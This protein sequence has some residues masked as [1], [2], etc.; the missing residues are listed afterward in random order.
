MQPVVEIELGRLSGVERSGVRIFR[1]IPYAAPPLGP[2]RLRPPEP[3]EPWGGVRDA[4]RVGAAAPQPRA[5]VLPG[6]FRA[7]LGGGV[8]SED[9]LTLNVFTPGTD[10]GRRPVLVWIHGGAFVLGTGATPIY[11]GRRLARGGDAVVV[12]LNYRLGALGFAHL[13][14]LEADGAA[15][16]VNLGVQDQV[17]AL[18]FVRDHIAAFGGD[19]GNVTVFGESAGAMSVGTLLGTPMA[20]PLFQRAILQSGAA[21]NV[22]GPERAARAADTL[23]RELG[24]GVREGLRA[25]RE[26]PVEVVLAAQQRVTQAL[27]IAHGT[28]PWQPAVD[29]RI[30]PRQPL[31]AIA[32]GEA[33]GI[34]V[35]AGT[36]RDEWKLFTLFDSRTR[37]LDAAGL[38]RR[39]ERILPGKD[40][41]GVA[42]AERTL[43]L[44]RSARAGRSGVTPLELWEAIQADRVFRYP[45]TR[46]AEL[47]S[48]H[49]P[50]TYQYLFE[51]APRLAR[52]R[53]GA[54]HALEI[55]FVFGTLRHPL[56]RALLG[57]SADALA[58]SRAMR[59]AWLSFARTGEPVSEAL[60]A[61]RPY[62]AAERA[63]LVLGPRSELVRAPLEGE[64]RFWEPHLGKPPA[65]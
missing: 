17:A 1:G 48:A 39:L 20:R 19:P 14:L 64:R 37:R 38:R 59:S 54:C 34:P 28:L 2:R 50:R 4:T 3:P 23:L 32:A 11:S 15:D 25:L 18:R 46:L 6:P 31:E 56:A 42:F 62:S 26:A 7:L 35:L 36:N 57:A 55:P 27:G 51:W 21:H 52:R 45:A 9:C 30:V 5:V 22:S 65:A 53:I 49:E 40:E 60:G 61:W 10:G 33:A 24:A 63:T 8:Q 47:Q 44:Y 58:L 41:D 13:G 12:T 16:S 29:G 43:E